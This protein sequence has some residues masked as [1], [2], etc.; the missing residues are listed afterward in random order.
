MKQP[1]RKARAEARRQVKE[2]VADFFVREARAR[3]LAARL[4]MELDAMRFIA[5]DTVHLRTNYLE[6]PEL[7][8]GGGDRQSAGAKTFI[9][10]SPRLRLVRTGT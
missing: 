7:P 8:D 10:R 5:V 2:N 1:S 9:Y 3:K 6:V 4:V